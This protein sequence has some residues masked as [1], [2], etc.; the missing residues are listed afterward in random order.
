[1]RATRAPRAHD[2]HGCFRNSERGLINDEIVGRG[3][4]DG[5][6]QMRDLRSKFG[7]HRGR[8][9]EAMLERIAA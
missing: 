7:D 2:V 8:N 1:M 6:R 4:R 5:S 3:S 9:S